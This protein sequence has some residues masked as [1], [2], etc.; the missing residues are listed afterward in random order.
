MRQLRDA[1]RDGS[2]LAAALAQD[3]HSFSRLYVGMVR[4]GEAGGRWPRRWTDLPPCWSA[5]A[6]WPPR[7]RRP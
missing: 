4:A 7:S 2:P 5:S 1:V 3:P 6:A